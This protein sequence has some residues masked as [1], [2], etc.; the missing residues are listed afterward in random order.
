M[1]GRRGKPKRDP[2]GQPVLPTCT[3]FAVVGQHRHDPARLLLRGDD[4][5]YYAYAGTG[6]PTAIEPTADWAIDPVPEGSHDGAT[7]VCD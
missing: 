1:I 4:G 7:D 6:Q 3:V 2:A 5:R